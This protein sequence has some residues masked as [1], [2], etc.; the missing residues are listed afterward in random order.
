MHRHPSNQEKAI[1]L[2]M[3]TLFG[4]GECPCVE[5]D[6]REPYEFRW[7][8]SMMIENFMNFYDRFRKCRRTFTTRFPEF[9]LISLI[10]VH[11]TRLGKPIKNL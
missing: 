8:L 6:D 4:P 3:F 10:H 11:G 5:H 9:E 1:N 2:S 7:L